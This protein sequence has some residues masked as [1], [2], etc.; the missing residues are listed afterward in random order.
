M[1]KTDLMLKFVGRE[2]IFLM[3]YQEA[4]EIYVSSSYWNKVYAKEV[5]GLRIPMH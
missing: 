5:C 1:N 2:H 4:N 3:L